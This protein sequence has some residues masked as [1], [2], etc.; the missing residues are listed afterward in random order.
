MLCPGP[1]GVSC[2]ESAEEPEN[3]RATEADGEPTHLLMLGDAEQG[4]QPGRLPAPAQRRAW[5]GP[6]AGDSAAE[7]FHEDNA[8]VPAR[9]GRR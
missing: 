5:S 4:Q 6:A 1:P 3:D 2:T 9:E 7:F 8:R